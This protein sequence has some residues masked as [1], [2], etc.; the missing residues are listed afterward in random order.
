MKVK[1][2]TPA[3]RRKGIVY[4]VPCK[5]CGTCYIRETRRTLKVSLG[6]QKQEVKSG[7]SR[8]GIVVHAHE[9]NLSID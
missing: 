2:P 3:D 1:T 8:K 6:E 9:S 4:K 7:D 5:E